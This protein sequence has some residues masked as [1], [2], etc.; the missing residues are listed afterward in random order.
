MPNYFLNLLRPTT[1]DSSDFGFSSIDNYA[2]LL[3]IMQK[4]C[5]NN[6]LSINIRDIK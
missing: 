1:A 3:K 4:S 2:Y 6:V 5:K